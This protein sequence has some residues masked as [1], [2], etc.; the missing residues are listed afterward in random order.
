MSRNLPILY[1]VVPC[2]NEEKVLP[3]T[4]PIFD[5]QLSDMISK[6]LIHEDSKI[7]Y[8]N[9]G[10]SDE[11]WN[12]ISEFSHENDHFTGISLSRNR[13]HQNALLAGLMESKDRCDMTISI[14]CDGQDDISVMNE[15][16]IQ[17]RDGNEIVY[18]V[19]INRKSDTFFKRFTA[20]TYYKVLSHMGGEVIYN[21]ADYRLISARVLKELSE[22]EEVNLYLRGLV[23]LLGFKSTTVEYRRTERV[24]GNSHYPIS[25]MVGL[26]FNGITNLTVRPLQLITGVGMVVALIS[27]VGVIWAIMEL[28][29]G[30]TVSGWASMTCII[31]FVSGVQLIS[32]GI[33]GE[34]I[35]KIY[36]ESKHRPRYIISEKVGLR[37]RSDL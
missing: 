2:Y 7:L 3:L 19:R 12:I 24:A 4:G 37:D 11:T 28:L 34:Y 21:H 6:G 33:I 35:G 10:S 8:V 14:D 26:A 17:Y 9:D 20:Q 1:I 30:N 15:M 36:M 16:V 18:G 32:L 22:F 25:K 23:P 5:K 31:C 29:R 13:G 27:F